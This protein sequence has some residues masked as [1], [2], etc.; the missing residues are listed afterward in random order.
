MMNDS[1]R[2]TP[3][4]TSLSL[5]LFSISLLI[6][7]ILGLIFI[8]QMEI[9]PGWVNNDYENVYPGESYPVISDDKN[10]DGIS[11]IL[12]FMDIRYKRD[13]GSQ[14]EI[15]HNIPNYGNIRLL[16]GATGKELWIKEY[17][18]PIKK[19]FRVNDINGDGF[20]DFFVCKASVSDKWMTD[21]NCEDC[22]E[23]PQ[24][25]Y[26]HF[27]N[28][29]I[30]GKN[31]KKIGILEGD[32][33]NVS[34]S[35]T[36]AFLNIEDSED[37]IED[38]ITLEQ[39]YI[40][41]EENFNTTINSYYKNGTL[42]NYRIVHSLEENLNDQV[43]FKMPSLHY[44]N[45]NDKEHL[46]Y[47]DA[48]KLMLLNISSVNFNDTIFYN[49]SLPIDINTLIIIEDLDLDGIKEILISDYESKFLLINGSDGTIINSFNNIEME[50]D[51][52]PNLKEISTEEGDRETLILFQNSKKGGSDEVFLGVYSLKMGELK[53]K[54]SITREADGSESGI[55]LNNDL[56]DDSISDLLVQE[57]ITPIL[58]MN[59]VSR[60]HILSSEDGE[61]LG[62]INIDKSP[63]IMI[64]IPDMNDDDIDDVGMGYEGGIIV[65][66]VMDPVPIFLSPD[67][68]IGF[69]L[70]IIFIGC[71]LF[72]VIILIFKGKE[73]RFNIKKGFK[74]NKLGSITNILCISIMVISFM[75]FLTVLNVFNSTI[76]LG[77]QMSQIV[78]NFIIISIIWFGMLPL[79]AAIYNQFA[80]RFAYF[81]IRL[82]NTIFK[83][84]K[85][86][87]TEIVVVDMGDRTKL[88]NF[89][90]VKRAL[91]PLL[92]SITVGFFSYNTFAPILNYPQGFD[93]FGS[94]EFFG[95]MVGY[96]LLCT[97][98]IILSFTLFSFLIAGIYLLDDAG[99]VYYMESKKYQKPGDIE[100]ISVWAKAFISGVAGI[101]AIMTFGEFFL[102]VDFSGFFQAEELL[103][104]IFGLFMVIV[105]F[106]G[107]PFLTAFC[108]IFLALDIM[109][110]TKENNSQK[111]YKKMEK[112]GYDT[113]PRLIT[114]LY[115]NG[116]EPSK[117][118]KKRY[119]KIEKKEKKQ[120]EKE[121]VKTQKKAEKMEKK[122]D[123]VKKKSEKKEKKEEKIKDK[124]E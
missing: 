24:M 120:E 99:V 44:F 57:K 70:F 21:P 32:T 62:E 45:H 11:E 95:F 114:N 5:I 48:T 13:G 67:V 56:D 124:K 115:P 106:W 17:N 89:N 43:E 72:G 30:N 64:N 83:I 65:L 35:Y 33:V 73:L 12:S 85:S 88:G 3:K 18:G 75:L 80:P 15:T 31:G 41:S 23:K 94:N 100:A 87:K 26:E 53:E 52:P 118:M 71:T 28:F 122:G 29:F 74:E 112:H 51:N 4:S 97:L 92:L 38:F 22:S 46:L 63:N 49:E 107:M 121:K 36:R 109:D 1:K 111:L 79:T 50:G 55:V 19:V 76:I 108:F 96:M 86:N 20:N 103:F 68:P 10:G 61:S 42:Q 60:Y 82:R 69:P 116:Y 117:K 110:F 77:N 84:S 47:A 9:A 8:T 104:L 54:W 25:Y 59:S 98:P 39:V 119:D 81:I 66:A 93:A 113:T 105:M 90:R 37:L 40:P 101:S 78:V 123:K 27:S 2:D 14:S 16:D 58:S 102:T 34:N 6:F 7:G 91:L